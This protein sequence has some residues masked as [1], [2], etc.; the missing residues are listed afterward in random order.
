[1]LCALWWLDFRRQAQCSPIYFKRR[2]KYGVI[3]EIAQISKVATNLKS[4]KAMSVPNRIHIRTRFQSIESSA[5][6]NKRGG[7]FLNL[8]ALN[9]A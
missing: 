1:M 9:N 2:Q 6:R 8:S 7:L 4:L 5:L 3:R